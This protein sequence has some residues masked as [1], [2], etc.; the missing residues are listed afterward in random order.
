MRSFR[1]GNRNCGEERPDKTMVLAAR[2]GEGGCSY[3]AVAGLRAL[4]VFVMEVVLGQLRPLARHSTAPHCERGAPGWSV[5]TTL[6]CE[7]GVRWTVLTTVKLRNGMK[8]T[9]IPPNIQTPNQR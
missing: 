1:C 4:H 3:S 9:S 8:G 2:R 6:Y 5:L 7:R